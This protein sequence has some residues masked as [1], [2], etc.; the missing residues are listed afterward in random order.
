[1]RGSTPT[2]AAALALTA[3]AVTLS[4]ERRAQRFLDLSGLSP[5][6]LREN[7][8]DPA[9]LAASLRFLEAFEPDL[10]AVAEAIGC[11]PQ[12]LVRAR[13]TLEEQG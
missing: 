7:A 6:G 13:E 3:L 1:M 5:D 11:E 8:G 9:V 2:D 10:V 12:A 4:D